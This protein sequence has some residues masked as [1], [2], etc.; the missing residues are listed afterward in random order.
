MALGLASDRVQNRD[1]GIEIGGDFFGGTFGYAIGEFDG[2]TDGNST[3]SNTNP[4]ADSNDGKKD[5][6]GRL[7]S[8]P[9][10]NSGNAALKGLGFGI[11]G[12]YVKAAG[13]PTN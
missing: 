2:V 5:T 4:D 11:A 1:L 13:S 6:E 7:F 12:T 3:D 10:I 8:Q 9:F